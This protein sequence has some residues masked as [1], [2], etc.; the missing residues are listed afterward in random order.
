MRYWLVSLTVSLTLTL[1]I[2]L[3]FALFRHRRGQALLFVALANVLT[4]PAVVLCAGLWRTYG[5]PFYPA[6][7]TVLEISA[8]LAEG[9][10]YRRSGCFPRPYRFSLIANLLSFSLGLLITYIV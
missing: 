9:F 10:V 4:N 8:V 1:L 5:L 2:E 7:V 6:A 3:A